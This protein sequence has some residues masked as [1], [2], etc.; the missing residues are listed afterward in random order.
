[1]TRYG[2]NRPRQQQPR[3]RLD[4]LTVLLIL[5]FGFS[6]IL[7]VRLFTLQV[8]AHGFYEALASGQHEIEQRLLPDR[9]EIYAH[10]RYSDGQLFPLATNEERFLVYAVPKR[11]EDPEDVT[12]KLESF[13]TLDKET[14]LAR[15]SKS[16]DVYEP[17]EHNISV[18]TKEKIEALEIDGISF[19][20]EKGRL[21]PEGSL[22]SQILGFLGM[23]E[24]VKKGQY[25]LEGYF[26]EELAGQQGYLQAE[27]DAAGRWITVGDR[28]IQDAKDGDDLIL[29]IDRTLEYTVCTKLQEAVLKHGA[30]S[31]AV[32]ILDPDSGAILAMCGYPDFD[33]NHYNEVTDL[34]VFLNPAISPYEPGSIFKP[35][36]MA[37]AVDT[38]KVTC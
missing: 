4:R 31:G 21:Y 30:E 6:S 36:T 34:D 7:V 18:A 11:I 26:D 20:S 9:G 27:R 1:M 19:I 37:T 5:L 35:I 3:W 25:G 17:I 29:T 32:V 12:E 16:D 22:A 2:R 10:D 38:G 24:D 13:I 33:P 15:L 23:S 8:L 28:F 14:L